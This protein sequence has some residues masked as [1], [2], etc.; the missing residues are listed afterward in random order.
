VADVQSSKSA[1]SKTVRQAFAS[2]NWYGNQ[3][4]SD[5]SEVTLMWVGDLLVSVREGA[6]LPRPADRCHPECLYQVWV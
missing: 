5:I 3:F 1:R 4:P 2:S 6:G